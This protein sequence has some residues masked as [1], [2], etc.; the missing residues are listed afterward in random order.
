MTLDGIWLSRACMSRK[1][2]GLTLTFRNGLPSERRYH[3]ADQQ[4]YLAAGRLN[5][6]AAEQQA[7]DHVEN[8]TQSGQD[9]DLDG[10]PGQVAATNHAP[11]VQTKPRRW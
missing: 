1:F 11:S 5:S 8:G 9:D 10:L 4:V 7:A 3:Q 2:N 6:L